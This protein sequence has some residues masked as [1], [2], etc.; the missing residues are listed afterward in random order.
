[1]LGGRGVYLA[2]TLSMPERDDAKSSAAATVPRTRDGSSGVQASERSGAEPGVEPGM[3]LEDGY[4]VERI[5]GAG[6]MGVVALARDLALDRDVAVKVVGPDHLDSEPARERFLAEARAM[7]RVRHP[8][9]VQIHAFGRLEDGVPFFVMEYVPGV[10]LEHWLEQRGGP[11]LSVGEAL[12]IMDQACRGVTAMHEAGTA[13]RDLKTSNLLVGPGFRVAVADLGLA[14]LVEQGQARGE[15]SGTPTY[16]A[17]EVAAGMEVPADLL[18]RADVYGLAVIAFELLTG[19]LPFESP[20]SL[21]VMQMQIAQ[22]PPKPSEV[23]PDLPR[24][25]D[26]PLLAALAKDPAERTG[27]A[28]ALRK[29]LQEAWTAERAS[30]RKLRILVA[31]DDVGFRDLVART[32]AKAYPRALV[33]TVDDGERAL[34][35]A[36]ASPPALVVSDLDMPGLNGVELTA[37]L[38]ADPATRRIP[39]LVATAV[40]TASDW[41]VLSHLGADGFVVKPFDPSVLVTTVEG[42][43]GRRSQWRPSKP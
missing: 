4:R 14:R 32:L 20:N 19:R 18:P 23:R 3:I 39:I 8:N 12:G 31:D 36:K 38:R 9:V 40:G 26:G 7:A 6:S 33:E 43:L 27:S 28:E 34:A 1:V 25:F 11:P 22:A 42:M 41:K 2:T 10:D 30:Q 16:M 17:P 5:L 15:V 35:A 24:A 13:H 29:S 37:A 21:T